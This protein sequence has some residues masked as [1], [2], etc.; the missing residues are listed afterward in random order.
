MVKVGLQ[1]HPQTPQLDDLRAA[2]KTADELGA[3]SLWIWDHF[4]PPLY[5]GPTDPHFEGWTLLAAMAVET[6][7][8]AIGMLVSC[9]SYR[10]PHL[11]A[12]MTRTIDHLAHG[13]VVLGLGSGWMERDY[14]EYGFEFGTVR[15]RAEG[16]AAAIPT[17]RDRLDRLV[18]RAV[19]SVPILIGGVGHQITLRTVAAHAQAWNAGG[20]P[21]AYAMHSARL[22]EC[23]LEIGRDP[24]SVE[25][26]VAVRSDYLER[27][28]EYVAA[29]ATHLIVMTAAP[30]DMTPFL[31]LRDRVAG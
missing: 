11:L 17:I 9:I 4:F 8:A 5:G 1:L 18:P 7:R 20:S 15:S 10:N 28:E 31:W 2:W 13:R 27:W 23:C 30:Y 29:G 16:L 21:E 19:G 25:R 6:Q 24:A 14:V 12:D 22:T 3:D 26:T